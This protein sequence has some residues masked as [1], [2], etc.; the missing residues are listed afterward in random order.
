MTKATHIAKPLVEALLSTLFSVI[1]FVALRGT[2]CR[3]DGAI[4]IALV[5]AGVLNIRRLASLNLEM[6]LPTS[7][8]VVGEL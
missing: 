2:G 5:T 6:F 8:S 4:V 7:Q 3:A 1:V